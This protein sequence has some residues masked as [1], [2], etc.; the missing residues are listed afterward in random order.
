MINAII[1]VNSNRFFQPRILFTA[2]TN[3]HTEEEHY[4]L[5]QLCIVD[6]KSFD[7]QVKPAI[8]SYLNNYLKLFF[9][10]VTMGNKRLD[11]YLIRFPLQIL[12]CKT[13]VE[14][15]SVQKRFNH[16][17]MVVTLKIQWTI[18]FLWKNS[19]D[20]QI[21]K[22]KAVKLHHFNVK[23]FVCTFRQNRHQIK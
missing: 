17:K 21:N 3:Q 8:F 23:S 15:V 14:F 1:N 7:V 20:T 4:I 10:S 5:R 16:F 19:L 22:S 11:R 18:C 13:S 12:G 6:S 2:M 9:I